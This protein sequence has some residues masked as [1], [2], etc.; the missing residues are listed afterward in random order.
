MTTAKKLAFGRIAAP[1]VGLTDYEDLYLFGN[2]LSAASEDFGEYSFY[3]VPTDIFGGLRSGGK[4]SQLDLNAMGS[5][6]YPS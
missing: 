5:M 1:T 3:G 6:L 2:A 4:V